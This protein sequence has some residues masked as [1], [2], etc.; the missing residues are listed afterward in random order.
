MHF[1]TEAIVVLCAFVLYW[2]NRSRRRYLKRRIGP[3]SFHN[4][5]RVARNI[6]YMLLRRSLLIK[7][8]RDLVKNGSILYSFHYG[9]WELMPFTL[10]NQGYK[11][12]VIV[13]KYSD[14]AS[15]VIPRL[16]DAMLLRFRSNNEIK[17][18]YRND[19]RKMIRFLKNGGVLGMLVDG[20]SFYSKFLNA[21]K[22]SRICNV[23]LVPFAAYREG[24]SG[25]L[26]INC[27]LD[28]LVK[29]RPLDYMWFY[30]SRRALSA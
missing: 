15:S 24:N 27:D 21:Q 6:G 28:K 19:V 13:N 14:G 29:K 16:A 1:F 5:Y 20:G 18:Y 9:I 17:V 12:G 22:L 7:G 25:V 11:V 26:E 3:L 8:A 4:V 30:K 23:P 10:C 2:T